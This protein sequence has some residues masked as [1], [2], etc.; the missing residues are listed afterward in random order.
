MATGWKGQ[1]FRYKDFF[2]NILSLYNQRKDLRAFLELILSLSTI[3]I[4][5]LFALKPTALTIISLNNQINS[6]KETLAALNQ[7]I[8]DLQTANNVFNQNQN[9][10]P[11][12]D[13]AIFT[14]PEP[15]TISKQIL[16]LATKDSVSLLGVSIGQI[17]II[18]KA[19]VIN[20]TSD[21]KPLPEKAQSMPIS[22]SVR[23]NYSS[24]ISFIKD[25]ESLRI[26]I[27]VDSLTIN[28]SQTQEGNVIVAVVTG[29]VP[30]LGQQ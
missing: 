24:I 20:N 26:P 30:F 16:G 18:G 15:D 8:S 22:I 27:K 10:I 23:G 1:Y 13:A 7:K 5:V 9:L 19:G 11:D 6:K 4:F 2:L 3:T 25:F 29:R 17:V 12:I 28:S 21:V 14:S